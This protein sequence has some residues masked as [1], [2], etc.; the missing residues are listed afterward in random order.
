[1]RGNQTR[2]ARKALVVGAL[3][4][5][6]GF[7]LVSASTAADQPQPKGRMNRLIEQLESGKTAISG[8][9]WLFVDFEHQPYSIER[10]QQAMTAL[11]AKKNAQGQPEQAPIARIPAEGDQESRWIVKQVLETGAL[12]I[13]IPQ[14]D[15]K[16]QAMRIVQ[17]MRY[18]QRTNTKYPAPV[19]RRGSGGPSRTW[20]YPSLTDE[21]LQKADLW[22]NNPQGELL[23]FP[24]IESPEGVKN[25]NEILDVPGV[26]G[27]FVGPNDLS[28]NYGQGPWYPTTHT[29]IVE[30]ALETVAKAC[31]AK[32]KYCAMVTA[33]EEETQKYMKLGFKV[34]FATYLKTSTP[35]PD[36]FK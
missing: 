32:K 30:Q 24:Q 1:M 12:G 5:A 13:V 21:Y 17:S 3:C 23:A 8:D 35:S 31:V 9:A 26:A 18:P 22:P 33:T 28:Q 27:I 11:F 15:T 10:V 19:G 25:I 29:P 34:I 14:V 4:L 2:S 20:G 6:A 7:G 16:E 36:I